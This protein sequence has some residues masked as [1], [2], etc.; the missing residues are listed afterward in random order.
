MN[1]SSR[2]TVTFLFQIGVLFIAVWCV[3]GATFGFY[4]YSKK[5]APIEGGNPPVVLETLPDVT[6]I[7]GNNIQISSS[8][9]AEV[10]QSGGWL[11]ILDHTGQVIYSFH[12]PKD[13]PT[14]YAPGL[15]VYDQLN[16][17]K[18]GYTLSTWYANLNNEELTWIYG[19]PLKKTA[20]V[21]QRHKP[22]TYVILI[23]IGSLL[24]TILV[25]FLF[26]RRIGAPV[27]HMM[28][29]LQ[30]LANKSYVE[31]ADSQGIPKSKKTVDGDLRK[32]YRMYQEVFVA[33]ED[34][35]FSLQQSELE[36][37]RME[38]T[39]EEW[40]TGITHDLRTPLSS[41]KGY[42]D[43]FT[44]DYSWTASEIREFG[45]VISDKAVYMEG[46]IEDLG[47][48]FRLK[49]Q[50]LPLNRRPENIVE[51][52]R[53]VVIDLVNHPQT[54]GQIV[55]FDGEV[56]QILYPVDAKWMTRA[57]D[58]LLT[59]SSRHNPVGTTISVK[60]QALAGKDS[61]DSGVRIEIRDNG[62]GMDQ[63][64][65]DR[66]FDR[67][68]RGTNTSDDQVKGSGLG[69][70]IAKQLIEAHGGAISVESKLGGGTTIIIELP[71]KN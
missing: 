21:E 15:L 42:A 62:T 71:P 27:L 31:P 38:Q 10:K 67:Y 28:N 7:H 57:L 63:E 59:N 24:V 6:T 25:A 47:L 20:P 46:L 61:H 65:V 58:N 41:V 43:L 35:A 4:L 56:E 68:Y 22:F 5:S 44:A 64:T 30:N 53:R 12:S 39:R 16:P 45:Q 70:A 37:K 23:F 66:L 49:N 60:V 36:R 33:L 29:W 55:L 32:P 14:S 9:L 40:I 18:F 54:A 69:T 19:E 48:T 51:I 3:I 50:D 34:L 8:V 2:I 26:G 17:T 13:V 52:V 1:L 11:Q